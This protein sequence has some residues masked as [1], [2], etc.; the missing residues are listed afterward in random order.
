MSILVAVSFMKFEPSRQAELIEGC[1]VNDKLTQV[2]LK[3]VLPSQTVFRFENTDTYQV[4]DEAE[5]GIVET[6]TVIDVGSHE[7][8]EARLIVA[9]KEAVDHN[10]GVDKFVIVD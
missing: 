10:A 7:K 5:P 2:T 1:K 9:K 4:F 8:M 3:S 6:R